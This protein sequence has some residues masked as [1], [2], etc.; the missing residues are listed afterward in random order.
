MSKSAKIDVRLEPE[1]KEFV[2]ELADEGEVTMSEVIS[3]L[4]EDRMKTHQ[5]SRTVKHNG[6]SYTTKE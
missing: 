4:I 2:K 1:L 6:V 5:S 3:G